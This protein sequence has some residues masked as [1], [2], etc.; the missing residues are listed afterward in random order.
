MYVI[1]HA[2]ICWVPVGRGRCMTDGILTHRLCHW[3]CVQPGTTAL[4]YR[5]C[6]IS[7]ETLQE[8]TVLAER[9]LVTSGLPPGGVVAIRSGK[10]PERISAVI[11][12]NRLGHTTL[13]APDNL[14]STAKS[15]VY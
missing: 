3:A 7:F 11:A 15:A 1:A 9:H 10:E 13:I 4:I 6:R 12:L 2:N 14:G 5:D 8:L